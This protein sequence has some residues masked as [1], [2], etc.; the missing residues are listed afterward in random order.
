MTNKPKGRG[1]PLIEFT[2]DQIRQITK[3]A[4]IGCTDS[5][6]YGV[7][8]VSK[9]TWRRIKAA[10]PRVAEAIEKGSGNL[11][12]RLRRYQIELAC[13]GSVPMLI[14]LGKSVLGQGANSAAPTEKAE[15]PLMQFLPRAETIKGLPEKD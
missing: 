5:E 15:N 1:R 11:A 13:S 14:H 3:L 10:D 12:V 8:G 4:E 7:I 6:M 9:G 2:D